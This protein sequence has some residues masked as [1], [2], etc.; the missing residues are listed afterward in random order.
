MRQP[1][2]EAD[3]GSGKRLFLSHPLC[4]ASRSCDM[5]RAWGLERSWKSW[6][7]DDEVVEGILGLIRLG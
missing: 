5:L 4:A 6:R 1:Q 2:I 3:V 7:M